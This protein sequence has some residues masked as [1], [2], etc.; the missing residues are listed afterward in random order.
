MTEGFKKRRIIFVYLTL[1][2]VTVVAFERVRENGFINYDDNEYITENIH[3]QKGLTFESIKW[4]FTEAHSSNW[5]PLTW[6]SHMTDC[7]LYKLNPAGHHISNLLLHILSTMLLFAVLKSMTSAIWTS[8]FVAALFAVH[9]LH[10]ESVAWVAERKDVLSGLFWMLTVG[11]Y[12]R[13]V[14]NPALARYLLV[15]LAFTFGLMA[16]PMLVTLPFVLLLLDYWP[17]ERLNFKKSPKS[18]SIFHL[19]LEKIP[20]FTLAAVSSVV[21]F[22][23]QR[24]SGAV[25]LAEALPM[26]RRLANALVSFVVY[27]VKM[28]YPARLAVYYPHLKSNLPLWQPILCGLIIVVITV[29]VI[30][31]SRQKR[32]L[33]TGWFWYLGTLVPVIGLVQ[34]G[35]QARADRYSYLPSIGIFIM[36]AWVVHGI[37]RKWQYRK[38]ILAVPAAVIIVILIICTKVQVSY[39]KNNITLYEHAFDV[40]EENYVIHNNIALALQELGKTDEAVYHYRQALSIRPGNSLAYSNLGNILESQGKAGDAV[41]YLY[42]A[43]ELEPDSAQAHNNLGKILHSQGRVDQAIQHFRQAIKARPDLPQAYNNMGMAL[44]AKGDLEAAANHYRMALERKPDYA[45]ARSNLGN[46]Y[47]IQGKLN[48]AE[49]CFR[50]A[51]NLQPDFVAAHNNMA[52]ILSEQGRLDEAISH[53]QSALQS[54]PNISQVHYGLGLA[55]VRTAQT[56]KG[57]EHLRR[58]VDLDPDELTYLHTLAKLLLTYPKLNTKGACESINLAEHAAKLTMHQNVVILDTLATAYAAGGKFKQASDTAERAI[59]LAISANNQSLAQQIRN[60]LEL[61][62]QGRTD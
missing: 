28:F 14:K 2:A 5:H 46:V 53:Y 40:T 15:L 17:L 8:A 51:I 24:S 23:I 54:N 47:R 11:A 20:L 45:E 26:K 22:L 52:G 32:F 3:V 55:L 18:V 9:P 31:L 44:K 60:R 42:R 13:Y 61:Y 48:A 37:S 43:L 10:V 30:Y 56:A 21:T 29:G 19:V 39:W 38:I 25:V 16:K 6:L 41:S 34:V 27:I 62:K 49:D 4:A 1:V 7:N 50:K 57:I 36:I 33:A 12:V 58:S 59:K 35:A